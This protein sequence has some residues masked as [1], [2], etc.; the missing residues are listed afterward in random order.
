MNYKNITMIMQNTINGVDG[1]CKS[2]CYLTI[3]KGMLAGA[4]VAFGAASSSVAMHG[5]TDVGIARTVAGCIF[6]VGLM[7]IILLGGELFTGDC[8]MTMGVFDKQV[9][10]KDML[11]KLALTFLSNM[12]GAILIALMVYG[13]GQFDYTDSALGAFTIKVAITKVNLTFTKAFLSGILCNI[14]V[15]VA[16]LMAGAATDIVGKISA[17]FFPILAFVIGG[18]EHCV[19]NMFYI[20]AGMLA[21]GN[22]RY[23]LKAM[24]LYGFTEG[25]INAL[26]GWNFLYHNLLPVTLGNM[27]GGVVFVVLPLYIIYSKE[28]PK[29][30]ISYLHQTNKKQ[31]S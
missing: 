12:A 13:S 17:V 6:P 7:M 21:A 8:L 29:E 26:N 31:T 24:E 19:A 15:C 10:V 20:P 4:F 9:K 18:Y 14:I 1:K 11:T 2:S 5:I 22:E 25:Q 16:V 27:V 23:V 3:I 28:K 30:E